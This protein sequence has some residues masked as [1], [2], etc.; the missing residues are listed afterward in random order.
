MLPMMKSSPPLSD[1]ATL[2]IFTNTSHY[3]LI[4]RYERFGHASIGVMRGT[5]TFT[6]HLKASMLQ[7]AWTS[8]DGWRSLPILSLPVGRKRRQCGLPRSSRLP[9]EAS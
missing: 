8:Y 1:T 9:D 7:K 3:S 6:A 2:Y 5:V 4:L